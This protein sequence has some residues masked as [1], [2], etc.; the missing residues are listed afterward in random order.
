[1]GPGRFQPVRF[2]GYGQ[3]R[4]ED[5]PKEAV[6]CSGPETHGGCTEEAL[7]IAQ[8]EEGPGEEDETHGGSQAPQCYG[9][10]HRKETARPGQ[11]C[12]EGRQEGGETRFQAEGEEG[13]TEAEEKPCQGSERP[14]RNNRN[15]DSSRC[16]TGTGH[17]VVPRWLYHLSQPTEPSYLRGRLET[18]PT[19]NSAFSPTPVDLKR[20]I[21]SQRCPHRDRKSTR[22]N[23][24]HLG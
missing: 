5:A 6:Q 19:T 23:S 17:G 10:A 11:S 20:G 13:G 16:G 4:T 7:A 12:E 14:G 21:W 18:I 8:G 1:I 24:S 22:L 3:H 2:H 15:S 9:S